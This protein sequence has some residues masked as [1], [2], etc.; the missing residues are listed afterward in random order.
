MKKDFIAL[1]T[2]R[3]GSKGL[4]RKNILPMNGKPL[5]AWTIEAAKA[6]SS[7]KDIYVSTDDEEI[8]KISLKYNAKIIERPKELA[9][10]CS[11]SAEAVSH[12]IDALE[13]KGVKFDS[14]V[15]LQPTSPLRTSTHL[16]EALKL[17]FSK[18]AN[19]VISVFEPSNTPIK[20]YVE[21]EDGSMSGLFSDSAPYMRRQDLPRVFQPNGAIYAFSKNEFKK[22]EQ[23]PKNR[24]YPYIMPEL[25]SADIDTE[26]DFKLVEKI[27]KELIE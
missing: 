5:I 25:F 14:I 4:P 21:K 27:M 12:A 8:A 18:K 1:I 20:S 9:S 23:F 6:C 3:G 26:T 22:Y 13:Y 16:E 17:F 7:V 10:D 24:V 11:S 19:F 15:L 2:A